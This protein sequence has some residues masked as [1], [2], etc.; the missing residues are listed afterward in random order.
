MTLILHAE[1]LAQALETAT[2][3]Q[4]QPQ[5]LPHRDR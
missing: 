5:P 4:A 3:R 2:C 1:A